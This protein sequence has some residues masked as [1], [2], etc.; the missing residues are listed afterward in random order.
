[1]TKHN[2]VSTAA[3]PD[4][5]GRSISIYHPNPRG[6]GSAV[7]LEPRINRD[8]EDRYN[9]FFLEMA[10]QQTTAKGEQSAGHATFDWETKITVKLGFNDV[11][12]WLLA[13]EQRQ[14][15]LGPK[16]KG[17]YHATA[18]GN[19]LIDFRWQPDRE[20]YLLSISRKRNGATSP[21]RIAIALTQAE[22]IGIRCLLQTGLF[23][24]TFPA[25]RRR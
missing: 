23:F 15:S 24:V 9:C 6:T 1:M 11:C 2:N 12:E 8:G 17:L 3:A 16:G 19:T 18:Q 25:F 14:E 22:A 13:L 4:Y 7:R 21:Q 20:N 5:K 10:A